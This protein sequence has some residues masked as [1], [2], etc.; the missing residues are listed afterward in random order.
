ML[1]FAS[2]EMEHQEL[3]KVGSTTELPLP[4]QS[5]GAEAPLAA[6]P[7]GARAHTHTH[8]HT[9]VPRFP[10]YFIWTREKILMDK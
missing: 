8:T 3:A 7:W 5:L 4:A 10:A 6:S 1:P 2:R 9:L